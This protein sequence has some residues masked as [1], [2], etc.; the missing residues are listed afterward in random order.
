MISH[1]AVMLC[2][3]TRLNSEQGPV[4]SNFSL[5]RWCEPVEEQVKKSGSWPTRRADSRSTDSC[6]VVA[7]YERVLCSCSQLPWEIIIRAFLF[8][9]T[10]PLIRGYRGN[11][12]GRER[13]ER[14]KNGLWP[15]ELSWA[16]TVHPPLSFSLSLAPLFLHFLPCPSLFSQ[17]AW[18]ASH[19]PLL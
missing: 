10:D 9:S 18:D 15:T 13:G 14:K 8:M 5:P 3:F 16:V 11:D 12:K 1:T 2:R 19:F 4:G 7:S 17:R 6:F